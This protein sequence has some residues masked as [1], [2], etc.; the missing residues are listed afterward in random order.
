MA[1][2]LPLALL[3]H[4]ARF[5]ASAV[6]LVI[7][8]RLW[9]PAVFG[10]FAYAG[11]LAAVLGLL[12][13]WGLAQKVVRDAALC[14]AS[15]A[16]MVAASMRAQFLLLPGCGVALCAAWALG[17]LPDLDVLL[18]LFGAVVLLNLA[19]TM[20]AACRGV[21]RFAA[22]AAASAAGNAA[23]FAAGL[24]AA[25]VW[26]EPRAVALALFAGRVLH[27][28]AALLAM[29]AALPAPA[30]TGGTRLRAAAVL[31]TGSLF[32]AEAVL[33]GAFLQIDTVI[34]RVLLGDDAAGIYQAGVRFVVVGLVLAQAMAAVAIPA[35]VGRL[36]DGA[37]FAAAARR[38]LLAFAVAGLGFLVLF[39]ALG[40]PLALALYGDAYGQTAALAPLFGGVLLAR[41]LAAGG[42]IVLVAAGEQRWRL[43]ATACAIAAFL[44]AAGP[45][46]AAFGLVGIVWANL[47]AL[48][49]LAM[50]QTGR[51]MR[52]LRVF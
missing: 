47:A 7:L 43:G 19:E 26:G 51:A 48:A 6:L 18:P 17:L 29:R 39:V 49:L 12:A 41:C 50:L 30:S 2:G 27:A 23:V 16:A 35:L 46:A 4:G 33:A 37:A 13:G 22:E 31:R 11:A 20:A 40:G 9:P 3:S 52:H 8:A 14:R 45:A 25:L 24:A 38:V 1:A 32:A 44:A 15:A 42:A 21:G 10:A 5:L 28:G 36:G 34:V